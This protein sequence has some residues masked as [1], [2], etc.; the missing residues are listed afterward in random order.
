[1]LKYLQVFPRTT[2]ITQT[3]SQILQATQALQGIASEKIK[4]AN[5][6]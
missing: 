4:Y 5:T 1:M 6:I 2:P 3:T